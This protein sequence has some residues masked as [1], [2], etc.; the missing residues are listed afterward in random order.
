MFSWR[1]APCP[2][3][4]TWRVLI[5]TVP[6]WIAWIF[7]AV[8]E[9]AQ[10]QL[11]DALGE[12]PVDRAAGDEQAIE[13][14]SAEHVERELDV[15]VSAQVAPCDA[16]IEHRAQRRAA[17]G[18]ETV[19]DGASQLGTLGHRPHEAGHDAG[20]DRVAVHL[21]RVAHER[22]QILARRARVR[23]RDLADQCR[24]GGGDQFVLGSVAAVD[25]GLPHPGAARDVVHAEVVDSHFGDELERGREDRA[26]EAHLPGPP[27]HGLRAACHESSL[28]Y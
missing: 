7:I 25:R 5:A 22:E 10:D 24:D 12:V 8:G 4:C 17:L 28:R 11:G 1:R 20:L 23:D 19:A 14:R 27:H 2:R 21:D 15:E 18:E 16:A 6:V 3:A 9:P 13:E 26:V